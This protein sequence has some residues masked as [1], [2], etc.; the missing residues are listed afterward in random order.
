M[1]AGAVVGVLERDTPTGVMSVYDVIAALSCYRLVNDYPLTGGQTHERSINRGCS[2]A[3][4]DYATK[5]VS[6]G[7]ALQAIRERRLP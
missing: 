1:K 7:S 4:Q 6:A 2:P 5:L 3:V